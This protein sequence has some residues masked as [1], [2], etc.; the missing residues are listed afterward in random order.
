[1]M[2]RHCRQAAAPFRSATWPRPRLTPLPALMRDRGCKV[3]ERQRT[4]AGLVRGER[5]LPAVRSTAMSAASGPQL[6]SYL[7]CPTT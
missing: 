7:P 1:M 5:H 4:R 2:K 3:G 6:P